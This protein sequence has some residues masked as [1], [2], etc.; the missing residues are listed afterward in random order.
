MIRWIS[1]TFVSTC[2]SLQLFASDASVTTANPENEIPLNLAVTSDQRT[3]ENSAGRMVAGLAVLVF[4]LGGA[5]VFLKK[6][7]RPIARG[8][9]GEIKVISQHYLGPKKSLAIVR[10]AGESI[11]IGVTD[12]SINMIKS[13]SLLDEDIP[14]SVPSRF[15]EV[16]GR[17]GIANGPS[18][19][20]QALNEEEEFSV[21]GVRDAIKKKL[22]GMR[23]IQ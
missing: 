12:H 6:Y 14:E 15:D 11:L 1:F 9:Q 16:L 23:A 7:A 18:V 8:Q 4:L 5:F 17:N 10:V 13:L 22:R 19:G 21:A 20:P 3:Q 2:F